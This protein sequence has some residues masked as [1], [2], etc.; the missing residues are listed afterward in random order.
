MRQTDDS[1]SGKPGYLRLSFTSSDNRWFNAVSEK[2][3][4]L[5]SATKSGPTFGN[6]EMYSPF[7][8]EKFSG[9][10]KND[11]IFSF[12]FE[13]FHFRIFPT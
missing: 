5:F 6:P 13:I 1:A 9:I 7:I 10:G 8:P 2:N 4:T 12:F 3:M 11:K